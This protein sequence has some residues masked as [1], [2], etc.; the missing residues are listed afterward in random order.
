M[1]V[2]LTFTYMCW[3]CRNTW[4][5]KPCLSSVSHISFVALLHQ[6]YKFTFL[7]S[8]EFSVVAVM[9]SNWM[10]LI[11][12]L[13]KFSLL[14]GLAFVTWGSGL[15]IIFMEKGAQSESV[16]SRSASL[17]SLDP[18]IAGGGESGDGSAACSVCAAENIFC[19]WSR[20]QTPGPCSARAEPPPPHGLVAPPT[21]SPSTWRELAG[22]CWRCLTCGAFSPLCRWRVMAT[23]CPQCE[24]WLWGG[25]GRGVG[26]GQRQSGDRLPGLIYPLRE[27][28]GGRLRARGHVTP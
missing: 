8:L 14:Q 25:G 11:G 24:P 23:I 15:A 6:R 9:W 4:S 1:P 21:H 27:R 17:S 22:R 2:C 5:S 20:C 7:C 16:I 18:R 12:E 13:Y 19:A 3:T 28:L 26:G 10:P